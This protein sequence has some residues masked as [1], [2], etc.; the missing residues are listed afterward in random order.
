MRTFRANDSAT[1]GLGHLERSEKPAA[2]SSA[3][4]NRRLC[5]F[6][7]ARAGKTFSAHAERRRK[8]RV[9]QPKR[10]LV[11]FVVEVHVLLMADRLPTLDA[12]RYHI[13]HPELR[14]MPGSA[15]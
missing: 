9:G 4:P 13:T 10:L 15:V 12:N 5:G 14:L 7:E 8:D 3:T 11:H 2:T 1:L 6:L